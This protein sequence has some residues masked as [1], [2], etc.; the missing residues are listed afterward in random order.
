MDRVPT[1]QKAAIAMFTF[2]HEPCQS[3][4]RLDLEVERARLSSAQLSTL[5]TSLELRI[6]QCH[7]PRIWKKEKCR[8]FASVKFAM[9]SDRG[10]DQP[11]RLQGKSKQLW[12]VTVYLVFMH[13]DLLT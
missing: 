4:T 11:G 5:T 7:V 1:K 13:F 9:C 12:L 10:C 6:T 8:Y 2:T 3:G